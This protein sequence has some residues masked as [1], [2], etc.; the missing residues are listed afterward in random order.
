LIPGAVVPGTFVGQKLTKGA[1]DGYSADTYPS[2]QPTKLF[3][4]GISRRTTTKQLRDHFLKFGRVLDC[5]AMRTPD[6]RSRGFGYVTLDSPAAAER[7]LAEPQMIDDRI[8]DL[9]LAV[10]ESQSNKAQMGAMMGADYSMGMSMQA[11]YGQTSMFYPCHDQSGFYTDPASYGAL[12]YPDTNMH[13]HYGSHQTATK[14]AALT[15]PLLPDCVDLLTGSL[16]ST[17]GVENAGTPKSLSGPL[18]STDFKA[19]KAPLGEVT[20]TLGNSSPLAST[21]QGELAGKQFKDTD[22]KKPSAPTP[23]A[24]MVSSP[25]A[26]V[27][28]APCFIYEDPP[29]AEEGSNA[30][31]EPP[32]PAEEGDLSPGA[33]SADLSPQAPSAELSPEAPGN[34]SKDDVP[35]IDLDADDLPSMGSALHASGE[36]R[37]C[38]FFA[39]GRCQNG[40]DCAFCHLPHDRRKLQA[41]RLSQENQDTDATDDS[42]FESDHQASKRSGLLLSPVRINAPPGLSLEDWEP[43]DE[44]TPV[45]GP[46]DEPASVAMIALPDSLRPPGLLSASEGGRLCQAPPAASHVFPWESSGIL[47][48]SPVSSIGGSTMLSTTPRSSVQNPFALPK[49][50]WKETRSIETQTDDDYTCP[51]CEER[52]ARLLDSCECA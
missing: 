48:T 7:S 36:C 16:L 33:P 37:R 24:V 29:A 2:V 13:S 25:V 41:L 8:V 26:T 34:D 17:P 1:H 46:A 22:V 19:T 47:A 27:N 21:I 35:P 44:D 6:G 39:K 18:L 43:E 4:G 32:S 51:H 9:K 10:P 12:R 52:C 50:A 31:T 49:S 5:V 28:E 45:M 40:K 20:N 14:P 30:S 11:L 15:G 23:T 38:N 3:I 42:A